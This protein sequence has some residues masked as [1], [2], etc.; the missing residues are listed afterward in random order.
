MTSSNVNFLQL[1]I[2]FTYMSKKKMNIDKTSPDEKDPTICQ[3]YDKTGVCSKGELCNKS[4]RDCA[5]SRAI[6]LHHIF[7]DPD[8]FISMLPPGVLSISDITRQR[9]VD[10]FFIDVAAMLMQFGQLDDMVLSGNKS[11]HLIGNVIGLFHD[12]DAALAAK[13]AL[14]GQYYAGRRIAVGFVPIPRL[15]L[16]ICHNTDNKECTN[17]AL[18]NFIHPL[19]PSPNVYN[20]C[21]PRVVKSQPQQLRNPKK[22][23]FINN[24]MDTL[25][26]RSTPPKY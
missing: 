19:E 11:D 26:N 3:F 17:G 6:V 16:A 18:C 14:D 5:I 7:P 9:L 13:I 2:N 23:R 25:Y 22:K 1:T 12:S 4:H 10:A 15:S 20:Q 24:P 21:F 8:V